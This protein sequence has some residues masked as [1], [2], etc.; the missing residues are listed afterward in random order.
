M[1]IEIVFITMKGEWNTLTEQWRSSYRL[2]GFP[3]PLW[4]TTSGTVGD[5][6]FDFDDEDEV[7]DEEV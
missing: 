4:E 2:Y 5:F 7:D 6:D 3:R 1:I